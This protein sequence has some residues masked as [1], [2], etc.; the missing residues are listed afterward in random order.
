MPAFF[1]LL[2][3]IIAEIIVILCWNDE[4]FEMVDPLSKVESQRA[5]ETSDQESPG[6]L[7]K[8]IGNFVDSAPSSLGGTLR[9]NAISAS[10]IHEVLA[11]EDLQSKLKS[12][13][14]SGDCE[15]DRR[16]KHKSAI[17]STLEKG[18]ALPALGGGAKEAGK[19]NPQFILLKMILLEDGRVIKYVL[20]FTAF[21]L[22]HA[23][24]NF[25][26][27]SVEGVCH[28][29]GYNFSQLAGCMMI[30]LAAIETIAFF[31]AP[32]FLPKISRSVAISFGFLIMAIRFAF[33]AGWYYTGEISPYWAVVGEQGLGLC[34]AVF[35]TIQADVSL[36]FAN[37]SRLFIPELRRLGYLSDE[38]TASREKIEAEERSVKMALRATMQALFDGFMSGLGFGFGALLCGI[39]IEIYSYVSLW[40]VFCTMALISISLHQLIELTRSRWSDTF[41]PKKGTKA[42]E[43]MQLNESLK[44]SSKTNIDT[45]AH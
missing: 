25:V 20:V 5:D 36:M 10:F 8:R 34:Y 26:F 37:Q 14:A 43:I 31:T 35:C 33:Y 7:M 1:I 6:D 29:R 19:R 30:S 11:S 40:K 45:P 44:Q 42:Y 15:A 32:W 16:S 38:R 39:F 22:L 13:E 41:R 21:G 3:S 27:L 4:D 28:E 17:S 12:V 18:T 9:L 2:A 23:P 24:M